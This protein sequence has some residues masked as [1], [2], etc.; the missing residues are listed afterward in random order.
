[1]TAPSNAADAS[2]EDLDAIQLH[3][4]RMR[5]DIESLRQY[6]QEFQQQT[7]RAKEA[8]SSGPSTA[9]GA[10][11]LLSQAMRMVKQQ[12]SETPGHWAMGLPPRADG[13]PVRAHQPYR[14]GERG[15]EV[16]VP[17]GRGQI[18]P[19]SMQSA[20][21]SGPPVVHVT[22]HVHTPDVAS[23]RHSQQQCTSALADHIQK[24]W[25]RWR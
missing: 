17:E 14:V 15:P 19:S 20:S 3:I 22:M 18:L 5:K 9:A 10:L 25:K 12:A 2:H 7:R 4:Q 16:F 1:M 21:V 23:F 6:L 24:A 8:Q 11:P 13:G